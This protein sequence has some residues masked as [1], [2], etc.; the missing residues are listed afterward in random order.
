MGSCLMGGCLVIP[1]EVAL[2]KAGHGRGKDCPGG[3][4]VNTGGKL[5]ITMS[6]AW[7]GTR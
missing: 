5:V 1:Q 4:P 2:Q 3:L 7:G 6:K